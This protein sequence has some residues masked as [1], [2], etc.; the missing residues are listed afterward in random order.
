MGE[1]AAR[2]L[3]TQGAGSLTITNRTQE[4]AQ[5]LADTFGCGTLPFSRLRDEAHQFDIVIT[6]TGSQEVL[7]SRDDAR[8]IMAQRRRRPMFVIDI[9]VPR[10]IDPE[11]NNAEGFFLYDIDDLQSVAAANLA[12]RAREVAKAEAVVGAEVE[13][14]ARSSSVLDV[15]PTIKALQKSVEAVR[16][17]ELQRS[18][19]KLAALT[20]AQR[21][22]VE[23]LTRGLTNKFLHGPLQ[24]LRTAASEGDQYRLETLREIFHLPD[25]PAQEKKAVKQTSEPRLVA[26]KLALCQS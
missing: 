3:L 24:T 25:G 23:A 17:A 11:A 13:R 20:P 16:Q 9:A 5:V 22:A 10:D 4:R 7:F 2:H 8:Q 1:L 12:D 26:A 18:A 14:F 19:S 21:E 15:V 6:S